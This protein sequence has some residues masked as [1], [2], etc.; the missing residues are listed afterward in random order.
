MTGSLSSIPIVLTFYVFGC[1]VHDFREG[2]HPELSWSL[3]RADSI[4]QVIL[5]K[6]GDRAEKGKGPNAYNG[7]P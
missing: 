7:R 2:R 5:K 4:S 6:K 3:R 1:S